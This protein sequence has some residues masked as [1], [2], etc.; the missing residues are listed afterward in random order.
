M[1][2]IGRGHGGWVGGIQKYLPPPK[3]ATHPTMKK[4]GSY[5]LLE[6]EHKKYINHVKHLL[7]SASISIFSLEISNFFI[8]GNTDLH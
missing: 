8:S 6:E 3:P 2:A 4:L 5:I 7:S 1:L